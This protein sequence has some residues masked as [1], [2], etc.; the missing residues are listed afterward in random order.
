MF[1][2]SRGWFIVTVIF[3]II[4]SIVILVLFFIVFLVVAERHKCIVLP[5]GATIAHSYFWKS[6]EEVPIIPKMTLRDWRGTVLIR[7]NYDVSFYRHP[8]NKSKVILNYG[9]EDSQKM[10]FYGGAIMPLLFDEEWHGRKWNEP[11]LKN[12]D[13]THIFSVSLYTIFATLRFEH[14]HTRLWCKTDWWP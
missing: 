8:S 1:P 5:N 12:P 14:D 6:S 7:T 4:A 11:R 3:V 9:W 2:L 10:S 13:D